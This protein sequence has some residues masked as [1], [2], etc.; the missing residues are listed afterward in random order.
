[1]CYGQAHARLCLGPVI[2]DDAFAHV[3]RIHVQQVA[4]ISFYGLESGRVGNFGNLNA[5]TLGCE[6]QNDTFTVGQ[7]PRRSLLK[8]RVYT[9]GSLALDFQSR[10][11]CR[12]IDFAH[13]AEVIISDPLPEVQLRM[14]QNGFFIKGAKYLFHFIAFG[15]PV[16][17]GHDNGGEDFLA[18]ERHQYPHTNG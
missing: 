11:H 3:Q 17:Q 16:M 2:V 13:R 10:R 6:V 9:D 5:S 12:L 14:P 1:M 7:L 18:A 8:I 15:L 4:D